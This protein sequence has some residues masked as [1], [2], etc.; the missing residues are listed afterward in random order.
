MSFAMKYGRH[1]AEC[2][3]IAEIPTVLEEDEGLST[4]ILRNQDSTVSRLSDNATG[5]VTNLRTIPCILLTN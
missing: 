1:N 5:I 3:G 4:V 2:A